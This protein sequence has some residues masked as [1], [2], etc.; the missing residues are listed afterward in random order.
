MTG[1]RTLFRHAPQIDVPGFLFTPVKFPFFPFPPNFPQKLTWR[2]F[3]LSDLPGADVPQKEIDQALTKQPSFPL[4]HFFPL[5]FFPLPPFSF[6]VSFSELPQM[7]RV[8]VLVSVFIVHWMI[9]LPSRF[10]SRP[11]SILFGVGWVLLSH[12]SV[13]S[14]PRRGNVTSIYELTV[15]GLVSYCLHEGDLKLVFCSFSPKSSAPN[16]FPPSG[17]SG[18]RRMIGHSPPN[19]RLP[20]S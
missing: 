4:K 17:A 5:S 8:V 16:L 15:L 19:G 18:S 9:P 11:S 7:C 6:C 12:F 2:P 14:P 1:S 13:A 10:P 20:L 3:F